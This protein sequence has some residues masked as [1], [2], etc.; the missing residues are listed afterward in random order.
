MNLATEISKALER[1]R[2]RQMCV[3][4]AGM[5]GRV[6]CLRCCLGHAQHIVSAFAM[7][8]RAWGIERAEMQEKLD[9]CEVTRRALEGELATERRNFRALKDATDRAEALL[10][11]RGKP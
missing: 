1:H 3:C 8:R 4:G 2:D 10:V 6:D 9:G 7:E 11:G 5:S